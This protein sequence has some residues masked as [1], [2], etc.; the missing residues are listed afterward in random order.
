MLALTPEAMQSA[1]VSSPAGAEDEGQSRRDVVQLGMAQLEVAR[2]EVARMRVVTL[3]PSRRTPLPLAG[4]ARAAR[5]LPMGEGLWR[6]ACLLTLLP[7]CLGTVPSRYEIHDLRV[8]SVVADHPE[9]SPGDTVQLTVYFED[10]TRSIVTAVMQQCPNTETQTRGIGCVGTPSAIALGSAPATPALGV[11]H[12][13][14]SQFSYTEPL[15]ILDGAP[16]LAKRYGFYDQLL[17]HGE[18]GKRSIDADKRIVVTPATITEKN[19]NPTLHGFAVVESAGQ[20]TDLF[21]MQ[22]GSSYTLRP[23]YDA[24][25]LEDYRVVDFQGQTQSFHEEASFVWSC[26]QSCV[27]ERDTSYGPQTTTLSIPLEWNDGDDLLV[28]VVMRDG[29]GGEALFVRRFRVLPHAS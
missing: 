28:N 12:V 6:L 5:P 21:A 24:A 10:P 9:V 26:A 11:P 18:D 1:K 3:S 13:F 20:A 19:R 8:I 4:E 29:R 25:S 2:L 7:A 22:R 14:A 16:T 27:I 17:F 15:D 23:L